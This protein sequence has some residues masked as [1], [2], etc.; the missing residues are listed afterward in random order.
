MAKGSKKGACSAHVERAKGNCL[1]HNRRDYDRDRPGYIN[2]N[3]SA[4]NRTVFEHE[5]I[6]DRKS[7]VG[8]VKAAE[9]LYTEK[10]GQKCQKSFAPFRE[11]VLVFPGNKNITDKQLMDFKAK[12]EK[13]TGWQV[14]G[15]WLHM[16]EGFTHSKYIEG[17]EDFELNIHAHVLYYCQ[18]EKTG[19]ALRNDRKFFRLR[20]DWLADATGMERGNP[21]SETGLSHRKSAE[22]QV[23]GL[24]TR[25]H[26]LEEIAKGK[27]L[28]ID[29]LEQLAKEREKLHSKAIEAYKGK[30]KA[31]EDN[32]KAILE[33]IKEDYRKAIEAL[34][35][36]LKR[37]DERKNEEKNNRQ[38]SSW[39][40]SKNQKIISDLED[41][42]K[43]LREE[44]MDV[45]MHSYGESAR[46]ISTFWKEQCRA[47]DPVL[48]AEKE[49]ELEAKYKNRQ[50]L[51]HDIPAVTARP[52]KKVA[53]APKIV[54]AEDHMKSEIEKKWSEVLD[55]AT[56]HA[57]GKGMKT[58]YAWLKDSFNEY[59]TLS[60]STPGY[61]MGGQP[62]SQHNRKVLAEKIALELGNGVGGRH[63][64]DDTQLA[65]LKESLSSIVQGQSNGLKV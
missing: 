54:K 37:Y 31:L 12:V 15:I 17:D 48:T 58:G 46:K 29:E 26:D 57:T 51:A 60:D 6:K 65:K 56:Q 35:K 36:R 34:E 11:D 47:L 7:I 5:R 20:Q 28:R 43:D 14:Y 45:R 32:Y 21:A 41:K 44:L 39:F 23:H 52:T 1:R 24:E 16:D 61:G 25:L 62:G 40:S 42:N 8:L 38:S 59:L 4:N 3:L 2:Y 55:F 53:P 49:K 18:D 30:L 22:Q 27:Q 50:G 9:K 64:L 63:V 13:E 10:T 33:G 19:K